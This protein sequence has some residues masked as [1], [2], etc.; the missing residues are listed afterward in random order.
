LNYSSTRIATSRGSAFIL[1]LCRH[2]AHKV[3]AHY[4]EHEGRVRFLQ[5]QCVMKADAQG[6]SIYMQADVP[7]K[8]PG[9]HFIIDDH[10][11]RFA[12]DEVLDYTWDATVPETVRPELNTLMD[13]G[14]A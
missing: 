11:K 5:G 4:S 2:F 10:L 3:P 6:L 8:I 13:G 9:M 7:E 1:K 12:R 14:Q